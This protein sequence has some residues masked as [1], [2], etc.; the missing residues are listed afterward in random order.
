MEPSLAARAYVE[1][2][3]RLVRTEIAPGTL[4]REDDLMRELGVGRTPVREAI[5]QLALEE[6]VVVLPR[7]GTLAT[8]VEIRD[9]ARIMDVRG[10]LEGHAAALAATRAS[11]TDRERL[12]ALRQRLSDLDGA[13]S[14]DVMAF[15]AD[16]HRAIHR[17][18]HSAYLERT[19]EIHHNL[20]RR[21]WHLVLDRRLSF[22]FDGDQARDLLDAVATGD[23]ERARSIMDDHVQTFERE[24]RSAL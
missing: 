24:M 23:A 19:L 16:M 20:A 6:L 15:D 22:P 21:I 3:E 1:L 2:R 9:L 10:P 5:R 12:E 17:A 11:R 18:T 4:L 13:S 8:E 14:E 7:R